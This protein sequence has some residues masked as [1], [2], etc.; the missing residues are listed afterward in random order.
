MGVITQGRIRHCRLDSQAGGSPIKRG[1]LLV[2]P[3]CRQC[4][5]HHLVIAQLELRR[6]HTEND[7]T[8]QQSIATSQNIVR[9]IGTVPLFLVIELG[10]P[11]EVAHDLRLRLV[12]ANRLQALLT[13]HH[14]LEMR[15]GNLLQFRIRVNGRQGHR[16]NQAIRRLRRKR[17]L[18]GCSIFRWS[19]RGY[20]R[21]SYRRRYRCGIRQGEH[22]QKHYQTSNSTHVLI[23]LEMSN[24]K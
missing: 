5:A 6:R 24:E 17:A 15:R 3:V 18:R 9:R 12:L 1:V 8:V 21:G 14:V 2:I 4:R 16:R 20:R 19:R 23:P 10:S 13:H 7:R 11:G 22:T